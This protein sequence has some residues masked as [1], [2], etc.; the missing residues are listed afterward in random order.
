[1]NNFEQPI[2]KFYYTASEVA[3]IIGEKACT[4]RY[5]NTVFELGAPMGSQHRLY[6]RELVAKLHLVKNLMRV[7]KYTL[8]G[9]KLKLK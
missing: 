1:M 3:D 8:A 4:V 9:A 7:E 2:N 6:S 5:W